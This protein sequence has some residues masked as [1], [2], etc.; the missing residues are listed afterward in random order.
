M[1]FS[2][3]QIKQER[4]EVDVHGYACQASGERWNDNLLKVE[5]RVQEWARFTVEPQA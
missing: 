1:I 4:V 5:I 3:G 2:F